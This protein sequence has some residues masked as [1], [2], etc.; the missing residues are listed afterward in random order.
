MALSYGFCLGGETNSSQFSEAF[1]QLVGDG[2]TPDGMQFTA[3]LKGFTLTVQPGYAL[4]SGRWVKSDWPYVF[5][6]QASGHHA[7]RTDAVA[8]RID[9]AERKAVLVVLGDIDIDAVREDPSIL[10]TEDEYCI[11]LYLIRIRRGVT[12]LSDEDMT[13]L[14]D[15]PVFCGRM[16]PLSEASGQVIYVHDYFAEGLD[17]E[18]EA[19]L[20]Y[21]DETLQDA[22]DRVAALKAL[23][24]S[25]HIAPGIG[26]LRTAY[27]HPAPVSEWILCSG[28]NVPEGYP[29]LNDLLNGRLPSLSNTNSRRKT[30]IYGGSPFR[31]V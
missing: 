16:M 7:D 6:L 12:V 11:L 29:A 13:D 15:D 4:V 5:T 17:A 19:L 22:A 24:A 31:E 8:I 27:T 2:I 1:F 9:Y 23:A 18:L 26:E 25:R 21:G 14:R 30:Y 28:G 10:R 3:A 20:T